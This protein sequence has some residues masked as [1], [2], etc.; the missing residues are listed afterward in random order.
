MKNECDGTGKKRVNQN[1]RG[2]MRGK[3]VDGVTSQLSRTID[4]N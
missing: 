2:Q 1:E 4:R 3:I